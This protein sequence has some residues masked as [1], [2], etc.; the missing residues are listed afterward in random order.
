MEDYVEKWEVEHAIPQEAY[1]FADPEDVKRCWSPDNVRGLK[2][3]DNMAKGVL[4]LD[5]LC[6]RIGPEFYPADWEGK[7][8]SEEEKEAFYARCRAAWEPPDGEAADSSDAD[9]DDEAA[10]PGEEAEGSDS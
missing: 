8:P 6:R 3:E 9:S 1:D 7:V 4:I 10:D 5:D 2:R